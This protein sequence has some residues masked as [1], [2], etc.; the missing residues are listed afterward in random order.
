MSKEFKLF[1]E[2]SSSRDFNRIPKISRDCKRFFRISVDV[3]KKELDLYGN[4]EIIVFVVETQ[5]T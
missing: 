5:F 4:L 2:T 3:Q 1:K